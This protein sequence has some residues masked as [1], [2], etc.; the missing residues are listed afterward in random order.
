MYIPFQEMPEQSRVWIYQSN[1]AFTKEEQSEI[2]KKTIDFISQ[3]EAHAEALHASFDIRYNRFLILVVD[4]SVHP[5]TGCSI[6]ESV[7]FIQSL[8]KQYDI[9]LLDKMNV[10][11]KKDNSLIY[12]SLPEFKKLI[13]S[14]EITAETIVFN[15]LVVNKHELDNFWEVP[16]R[17]SWHSRYLK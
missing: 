15:N 17:E 2:T 13:K 14:K 12:R 16:L 11:F 10:V 5:P 6:D 4:G 3:W 7:H 8:E 9:E 1:R